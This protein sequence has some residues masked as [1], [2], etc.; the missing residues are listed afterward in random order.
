MAGNDS[1]TKRLIFQMVIPALKNTIHIFT[2]LIKV[3]RATRST[4]Q[5]REFSFIT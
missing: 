1:I 5:G 2:V 3:R 4:R